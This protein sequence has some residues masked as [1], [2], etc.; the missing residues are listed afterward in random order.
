MEESRCS[1]E[2]VFNHECKTIS[3]EN[4]LLFNGSLSGSFVS[5]GEGYVGLNSIIDG[6]LRDLVALIGPHGDVDVLPFGISN[7]IGF[8]ESFN[9]GSKRCPV[10]AAEWLE[11][12]INN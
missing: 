4:N 5:T 3:T 8:N 2:D 7:R 9:F 12:K 6:A 10:R 11:I 1:A